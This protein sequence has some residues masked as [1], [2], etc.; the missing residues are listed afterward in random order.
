M[1]DPAAVGAGLAWGKAAWGCARAYSPQ[2][3]AK[4]QPADH[5]PDPEHGL[6]HRAAAFGPAWYPP[7]G[8][9]VRSE[10]FRQ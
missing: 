8:S 3:G 1:G 2:L 4:Y 5:Y 10:L 7:D 9:A 6:V